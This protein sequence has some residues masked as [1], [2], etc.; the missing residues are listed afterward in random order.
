MGL[1]VVKI[2]LVFDFMTQ[3]IGNE[4]GEGV[5]PWIYKSGF[6]IGDPGG[7]EIGEPIVHI[8]FAVGVDKLWCKTWV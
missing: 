4:D 1:Y 6:V 3:G 8:F 2:T 7:P 5:S